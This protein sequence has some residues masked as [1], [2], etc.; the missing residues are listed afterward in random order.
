[1][2]VRLKYIWEDVDRHG[3]VRV[4]V[5]V[6]GRNKVRIRETPNTPEFLAAYEDAVNG[7]TPQP[8][9]AGRGTFGYVCKHYYASNV[10]KALD[11]DTQDWRRRALDDIC[12]KDGA[13]PIGLLQSKHV[14]KLRDGGSTP[15]MCNQRLAALKALFKWAV[16][17]GKAPNNPAAGVEELKVTSKGHHT[18]TNAEITQYEERHPVGTKA[19]LAFDLLRFTTCRREDVTRLGPQHERDRRLVYTQGKNENRSP[20]DMNIPI[21]PS[22]RASIDAAPSGQLV[23]VPNA[24]GKPFTP[25][26]FNAWFRKRCS[27]AKLPRRCTPHGIRKATLTELA[28]RGATTHEMQGLSGHRTLQEL[29]VYTAAVERERMA[30]NAMGK[31]M[32]NLDP[33]TVIKVGGKTPENH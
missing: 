16:A 25:D 1:M 12:E 29:Q 5:A 28:H 14:I 20:V 4:Y 13:K 15:N 19:R 22:L 8:R 6:P 30:D 17:E 23:F 10:F 9:V 3:N 26:S 27:E 21:H 11:P 31:L 32:E 18:W 2:E 7:V 33:P 24:W